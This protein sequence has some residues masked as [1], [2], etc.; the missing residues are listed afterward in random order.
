[1]QIKSRKAIK[2][3]N[4]KANKYKLKQE[5]DYTTKEINID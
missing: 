5:K 3:H 4:I 1:M 2:G